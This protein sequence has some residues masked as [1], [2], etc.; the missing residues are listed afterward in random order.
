MPSTYGFSY[1]IYDLFECERCFVAMVSWFRL[2]VF[3]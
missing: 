2:A 1:Q 3:Q